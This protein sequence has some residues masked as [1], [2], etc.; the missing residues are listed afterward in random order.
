[1]SGFLA[2][3]RNRAATEGVDMS[4]TWMAAFA[5]VKDVVTRYGPAAASR[6]ADIEVRLQR[7]DHMYADPVPNRVTCSFYSISTPETTVNGVPTLT[8]SYQ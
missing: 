3:L 6:M 5:F 8:S 2:K 1:V 7:L 4:A